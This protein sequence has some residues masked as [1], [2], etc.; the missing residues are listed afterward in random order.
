MLCRQLHQTRVRAALQVNRR[1]QL[2]LLLRHTNACFT[3]LLRCCLRTLRGGHSCLLRF[4]A[5]GIQ[6]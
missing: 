2:Q 6:L 5:H 1:L 3:Q 4:F